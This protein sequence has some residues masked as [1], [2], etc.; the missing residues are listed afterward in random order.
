MEVQLIRTH[1]TSQTVAPLNGELRPLQLR[2][3]PLGRLG[4]HL[5]PADGDAPAFEPTDGSWMICFAA[6][7]RASV[8]RKPLWDGALV[9]RVDSACDGEEKG[10]L[11]HAG[12]AGDHEVPRLHGTDP[13]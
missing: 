4:V 5:G 7:P 3:F 11:A 10:G 2:L 6:G 8:I 12:A 13:Q 1:R 9:G